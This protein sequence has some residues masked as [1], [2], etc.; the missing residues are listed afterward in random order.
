VI[1]ERYAIGAD[2]ALVLEIPTR[3]TGVVLVNSGSV[4]VTV[5]TGQSVD[6]GFTLAPGA[7]VTVPSSSSPHYATRLYAVSEGEVGELTCYLPEW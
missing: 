1:R 7:T 4:P 3:T 2:P 5:D 6:S